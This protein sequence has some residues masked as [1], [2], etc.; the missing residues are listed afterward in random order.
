LGWVAPWRRRQKGDPPPPP[1]SGLRRPSADC[2]HTRTEQ[3]RTGEGRGGDPPGTSWKKG[4]SACLAQLRRPPPPPPPGRRAAAHNLRWTQS[5]AAAPDRPWGY[6][7]RWP[8]AMLL[9]SPPPVGPGATP[10]ARLRASVTAC[11]CSLAR[12]R[13]SVLSGR[14]G[15]RKCKRR[16][17]VRGGARRST[18]NSTSTAWNWN[19]PQ[20]K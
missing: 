9:V 4:E 18:A 8:S 5:A 19:A 1:G 3:N 14:K 2:R 17:A 11:G 16:A 20:G 12:P 6:G 7:H 15:K 13:R 10:C